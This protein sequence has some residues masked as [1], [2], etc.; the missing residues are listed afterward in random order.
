MRSG[1][2]RER[3]RGVGGAGVRGTRRYGTLTTYSKRRG[4]RSLAAIAAAMLMASVLAVVAGAPAQ[5]ANTSSEALVDTN[6]DGTPDAREFGG[7]DR[8]DTA[9]R[10]AMNFGKRN[11]LGNV[12]TAF[13]ASGYT[14]VDAVAVAGLAGFLDAPVLLTPMDSLNGGVANFIED[15]GV[16][17]VHV[18]GGSAAV[19][20]SVVEAIEA[21]ANKPTVS[22]IE[23]ADRYATA[24]AI[25]SK[26]SGGAPWCGGTEAAAIL[27]NG[28]DVS[29]AYAMASGTVAYSLEMPLLLTAADVLPDATSDFITDQDIRHVV[30]V[31]GTSS[32]SDDVAAELTSAGVTTVTRIEGD[33][34]GAASAA[35]AKLITNG[36]AADLAPV[37]NDTVA[38]V[39]ESGLPDGVAAAPVLAFSY[40]PRG[41]LVPMLVVDDTLPAEVRDYLA[42]TPKTTGTGDN[43]KK[44]NLSIVAVGGTAAVSEEVMTAAV[45]A[46]A[47]ADALTAQI[48]SNVN[49]DG[50]TTEWKPPQKGDTSVVLRFSDNV[51]VDDTSSTPNV[52]HMTNL[53]RD[54]L[55]INGA[56]VQYAASNAIAPGTGNADAC[57]PDTVTVTLA[58]ALAAGDVITL[59]GGAKFGKD[60]DKRTVAEVSVTVPTPAADTSPPVVSVVAIKATRTGVDDV[61]IVSTTATDLGTGAAA[62]IAP[63]EITITTA[64][65]STTAKTV[66]TVDADGNIDLS[67]GQTWAVGDQISVTRGA[68]M[69]TAGNKSGRRSFDVIAAQNSPRINAVTMSTPKHTKQATA[70]VPVAIAPAVGSPA[71]GIAISAKKGGAA[72]GAAGNGW[73]I[74]FDRATG[75]EDEAKDAI[76]IDVRVNSKNRLVSVTF[77]TGKAKFADLKAALEGNSAFDAMFK[78]TLPN[79][80]DGTCGATANNLLTGISGLVRGAAANTI[81][82]AGGLTAV[83]VEVTF[84]AYAYT[85]DVDGELANDVFAQVIDRYNAVP[86][87]T[88]LDK[89]AAATDIN[90]DSVTDLVG[91]LAKNTDGTANNTALTD[92]TGPVTKARYELETGNPLMLPMVRDLVTTEAGCDVN[93]SG[94]D[95]D[96]DGDTADTDTTVASVA[97]GYAAD[98]DS[99]TTVQEDKNAS[100][101]RRIGQS[102]NVKQ[103]YSS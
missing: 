20:D 29:L 98:D 97:G 52:L 3:M 95:C 53:V 74:A 9:N 57:E 101:Q 8:Y 22:R 43:I 16:Q 44:L 77:K 85:I 61:A 87:N 21:L 62:V 80:T 39:A 79:A 90:S 81:T 19:A 56:P 31:G 11:G 5:A 63:S 76:D 72:D 4:R 24:A 83:A 82:T 42:A 78:V 91:K 59:A 33:T 36:C 92:S 2:R 7:R 48:T 49:V 67:N 84:N 66:N 69:D 18:L 25:A 88:D 70:T 6:A 38:L 17:T 10:L 14:L 71:V 32:V 28:G 64:T 68:L 47:S 23:G 94:S 54:N 1:V 50:S 13:V 27:A 46:A 93:T 45:A 60:G 75:W 40:D 12:S 96:G 58:N 37:S 55:E 89:N 86:A 15:Y 51:V 102:S 41:R 100:S 73:D 99:T 34:P 35:L 103:P 30:I 65:G 26:L